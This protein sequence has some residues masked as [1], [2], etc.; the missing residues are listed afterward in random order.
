V[1]FNVLPNNGEPTAEE[2]YKAQSEP[3][4]GTPQPLGIITRVEPPREFN[5]ELMTAADYEMLAQAG[6]TI[7]PP[8]AKPGEYVDV[9][10]QS[11]KPG[12]IMWN[13]KKVESTSPPQHPTD[14]R[15][16]LDCP[17]CL[18]DNIPTGQYQGIGAIEKCKTCGGSKRV[19]K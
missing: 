6:A 2:W 1:G 7:V 17:D 11:M 10:G 13:R 19:L 5:P 12:D 8:N 18:V 4:A 9:F 14:N 15:C 16:M 3:C